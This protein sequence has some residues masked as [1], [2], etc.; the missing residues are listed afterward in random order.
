VT[1]SIIIWLRVGMPG[2]RS[3]RTLTL[4]AKRRKIANALSPRILPAVIHQLN[5]GSRGLGRLK[6]TKGHTEEAEVTEIY[7]DEEVR[8]HV[9][10]L[11]QHVCTCRE[12]QLTGKPCSH[13]LAVITTLSNPIWISMWTSTTQYGSASGQVYGG[14]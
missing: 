11:P 3:T 1:T 5:V 10:Y 13:A 8:R 2:S 12:W 6:V 9:V 4:F 14:T 7:K